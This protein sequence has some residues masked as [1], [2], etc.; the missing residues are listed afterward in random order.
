M[1]REFFEK[2]NKSLLSHPIDQP[3]PPRK[4]INCDVIQVTEITQYLDPT[5]EVAIIQRLVNEHNKIVSSPQSGTNLNKTKSPHGRLRIKRN[6]IYTA[7]LLSP[8]DSTR[9]LTLITPSLPTGLIDSGEI[10]LLAS[11]IL[12][13]PRPIDQVPAS[14]LSKAGGIGKKVLWQVTGTGV[15]EGRVWAARLAPIGLRNGETIHTQDGGTPVCVLACRKGGRPADA[16]RINEW[17]PVDEGRGFVFESVVGEKVILHLDREEFQGYHENYR[18]NKRKNQNQHGDDHQM[19][20]SGND[21]F[22]YRDGRGDQRRG[23][24]SGRGRSG[25]VPGRGARGEGGRNFSS[26]AKGAERQRDR[27]GGGG[28]RRNRNDGQRGYKSLDDYGPSGNGY[29]G[30]YEPRGGGNEGGVPVMNY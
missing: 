5:T 29:D 27:Q 4:P 24:F 20:D 11:S 7:Y 25:N 9:L 8:Q 30:I 23:R 10:K 14:I 1:F 16:N 28:G 17:T 18:G 21:D 6:A 2:L 15:L 22:S 12:I 19:R 3:S 13:S 26:N